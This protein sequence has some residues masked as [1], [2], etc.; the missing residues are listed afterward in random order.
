[1][2][3]RLTASLALPVAAAL[4]LS[5]CSNSNS[6]SGGGGNA[7]PSVADGSVS[8][9]G[10]QPENG[11]VPANTNEQGGAKIID[12]IFTGLVTLNSDTSESEMANAESITTTDAQNY[13]IKLKPG[14]KFTDGTA[15]TAK[16]YVDA[17][18]WGAYAPNGALNGPFFAE[19]EGYSDLNPP[20]ATKGGTPPTPTVKEMSGV[21][22]VSDTEFTVKLTQPYSPWMQKLAYHVFDPMPA[23][24]YADPKAFGRNP[25]GDGPFKFVSWQDNASIVLTRNDDYSGAAK[26]TIKDVT[27]KLYQNSDAAY[28]DLQTGN[29]DFMDTL[30][31]S[32]LA[33]DKYKADLSGRDLSK[34]A[35]I[36]DTI[37]VPLYDP[38]YQSADLR[39]AISMAVDRDSIT[40][41][42]FSGARAPSTAY[43]SP[44]VAGY[45]A[46][47]CGEF[48]T[49]DPAKA[50][51]L[52]DKA[53]GFKGTLTLSYNADG[54]HKAWTEAACNNISQALGVP[55]TATPVPTFADFRKGI[56]QKAE[57]GMFRSGWA[58]DF[59]N[60]ENGLS[61][62]YSTG[63]SSNDSGY[64]NPAFDKALLDAAAKTDP[65]AANAGFVDAEKLLVQ[66]MPAIPLW[67]RTLISGYSEKVGNAKVTAQ[68]ELDLLQV[69]TSS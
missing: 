67:S 32:A 38:A 51:A 48:C 50:K 16:S 42:I 20:A 25:V 18:N 12:N 8:I 9:F 41:V 21:K 4:L 65:A 57:T 40:K 45:K 64:S 46:G 3:R 59:P 11:L 34:P 61:P 23:S 39:H 27:V 19:V 30:P 43:S 15:I 10:S 68:G 54:D 66:D 35:P 7:A 60:L 1:M 44:V 53:G 63:A 2:R 33:G 6:S 13:D 36:V 56:N 52:F 37:T 24:F 31:T 47:T 14:W 29:L 17:W 22:V 26:P 5:G 28:A 62:L 69:T 49:Y 58:Y 55:C